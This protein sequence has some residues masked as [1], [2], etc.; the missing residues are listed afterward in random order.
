MN[1][2]LDYEVKDGNPRKH[3]IN[4]LIDLAPP[5]SSS[6]GLHYDEQKTA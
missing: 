4:V 2:N 5:R 3:S 6:S 1:G